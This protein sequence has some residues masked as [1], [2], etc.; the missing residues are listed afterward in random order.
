MFLTKFEE[1][2]MRYVPRIL[3]PFPNIIII[4]VNS[5]CIAEMNVLMKDRS[6]RQW[7]G[8]ESIRQTAYEMMLYLQIDYM[9]KTV[10]ITY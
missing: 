6:E 2:Y 3:D 5:F 9:M 10:K 7:T 8:K 4:K 1:R